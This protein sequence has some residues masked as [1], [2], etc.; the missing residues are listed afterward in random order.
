[1]YSFLKFADKIKNRN[2]M[3]LQLLILML[4]K[5]I[6]YVIFFLRMLQ[7][8]Y[9]FMLNANILLKISPFKNG[10]F[11]YIFT[12]SALYVKARNLYYIITIPVICNQSNF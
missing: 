11:S 12:Q 10:K 2:I 1:M 8:V 7:K 3:V 4:I 5:S 6:N 9:I